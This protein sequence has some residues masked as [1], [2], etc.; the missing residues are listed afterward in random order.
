[1]LLELFEVVMKSIEDI[2]N[3]LNELF[4]H[5]KNDYKFKQIEK[6]PEQ[7][8]ESDEYV[9]S[10]DTVTDEGID[11][12]NN[13]F[14]YMLF[15]DEISYEIKTSSGC[16]HMGSFHPNDQTN[17][18]EQIFLNASTK[19]FVEDLEV[20]KNLATIERLIKEL[21]K[22]ETEQGIKKY[23]LELN[24][25]I[26]L[27]NDNLR[28]I[29]TVLPDIDK[30][31]LKKLEINNHFMPLPCSFDT[32]AVQ[33]ASH[34]PNKECTY[35]R[36]QS[37]NEYHYS[38][39]RGNVIIPY[40]DFSEFEDNEPNLGE[41]LLATYNDS[42]YV[43]CKFKKS[44]PASKLSIDLLLEKKDNIINKLNN[45]RKLTND[46]LFAIITAIQCKDILTL[47][48]ELNRFGYKVEDKIAE[49]GEAYNI[50]ANTT[51]VDKVIQY[52]SNGISHK[53]RNHLSIKLRD[54]IL[55]HKINVVETLV[56]NLKN[57]N[58]QRIKVNSNQLK[59]K[60][61]C[62][63][64]T[65]KH[66]E[67]KNV[68]ENIPEGYSEFVTHM[69]IAQINLKLKAN[70][71]FPLIDRRQSFGFLT[72]TLTDVHTGVR[73]S[74]GLT[75]NKH[76]ISCVE[77]GI[78]QTDKALAQ[79]TFKDGDDLLNYF[80]GGEFC[81]DGHKY[82]SNLYK[83][84]EK[85]QDEVK[86]SLQQ[87]KVKSNCKEIY[88]STK[89]IT[90][91]DK[92]KLEKGLLKRFYN[93]DS[94]N[95]TITFYDNQHKDGKSSKVNT[96]VI[97]YFL[98][99]NFSSKNFIKLT[100]EQEYWLTEAIDEAQGSKPFQHIEPQYRSIYRVIT[101][102]YG[103]LVGVG[104]IRGEEQ[105]LAKLT[106]DLITLQNEVVASLLKI[107]P[108]ITEDTSDDEH[109][110]KYAQ[111]NFYS[112]AGMS[113]LFA[114]LYAAA[115]VFHNDQEM[116][117]SYGCDPYAYFELFLSW[118]K[119]LD[120]TQFVRSDVVKDKIENRAFKMLLEN[121]TNESNQ[122]GLAKMGGSE[123]TICFKNIYSEIYNHQIKRKELDVDSLIN[124]NLKTIKSILEM[125]TETN[126][127]ALRLNEEK[128]RKILK[129]GINIIQQSFPKYVTQ[130]S[131]NSLENNPTVY[132]ADNNP[133]VNKDHMEVK[134]AIEIFNN[135]CSKKTF[136]KA[137]VLDTTSAT[138]EQIEDFLNVFNQQNKIPILVTA[139]SMVKHCEFGLDLWQGG[140]N[141][142]Y[143][144]KNM[145]KNEHSQKEFTCFVTEL[146]K[147]TQG[148]ESGFSRFARRHVR[149]TLNK[150]DETIKNLQDNI[151][152]QNETCNPSS[153]NIS[154]N[155]ISEENNRTEEEY[156]GNS[157]IEEYATLL[158]N[159][160]FFADHNG[161]S[162]KNKVTQN[163]NKRSIEEWE[164]PCCTI[165]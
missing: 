32:R 66:D 158:T 78:K 135:L 12:D 142:V 75:P 28:K 85:T 84:G 130:E 90:R 42:L 98:L 100:E 19:G 7:K 103:E 59:A 15:A 157:P 86:R 140:I 164:Q 148:T 137:F 46:E 99:K 77:E 82:L 108:L 121:F 20:L 150:L 35:R 37:A 154:S 165:I 16:L 40:K 69:M 111:K 109:V 122:T 8:T 134:T 105:D 116:P 49:K 91:I 106:R 139:S 151:E 141:K 47:K 73:L 101:R 45:N 50:G 2:R 143:L 112:P 71:L 94:K 119:T 36:S 161:K 156:T 117:F 72:P 146:K 128:L 54:K 160:G 31:A 67:S 79:F 43:K 153:H 63:I 34:V 62:L 96:D 27:Y 110:N 60:Y 76:W 133:C 147:V 33:V 132:F 61:P 3:E 149:E 70:N 29:S 159:K 129:K 127:T 21:E 64:V 162:L 58:F 4:K 44:A 107:M 138:E 114:P 125:S 118:N 53:K 56:Q 57:E 104:K 17:R 74:L 25:E 124:S 1:M 23:S 81:G 80:R 93:F 131:V 83:T 92:E 38:D 115:K 30:Q 88:F 113:A 39:N 144:S 48:N 18:E 14:Y 102:L 6:F 10:F 89:E 26:G 65:F 55:E 68:P 9:L 52:Q 145:E 41:I 163:D 11:R 97:D 5:I 155:P 13:T 136:P 152:P 120:E 87:S 24:H 123:V 51:R 22:K 95:G 126:K